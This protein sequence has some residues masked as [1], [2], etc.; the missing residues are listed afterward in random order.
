M[1][2]SDANGV[3]LKASAWGANAQLPW[4]AGV[5]AEMYNVTVKKSAEKVGFEDDVVIRFRETY[6]LGATKHVY[7]KAVPWP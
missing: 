2:I 7:F 6:R 3:T 1:E 4:K 5:S